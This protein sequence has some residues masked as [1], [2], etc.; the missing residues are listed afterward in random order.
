MD[1]SPPGS[2]SWDSPDRNTGVGYH[3][4]LQGI[5]PTQGSNQHLFCLLHWEVSSLPLAPSG[6]S[7]PHH[8]SLL[9]SFVSLYLAIIPGTTQE[10]SGKHWLDEFSGYIL[11]F[12]NPSPI[13]KI[14]LV[15]INYC[16]HWEVQ[17][18]KYY[19]L[20]K[21]SSTNDLSVSILA[22]AQSPP[23][24]AEDSARV[25]VHLRRK[26][27]TRVLVVWRQALGK[28]LLIEM[29]AEAGWRLSG[30]PQGHQI[31]NVENST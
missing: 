5:S 11:N 15:S 12:L 22:W 21:M 18:F 8:K 4:F 31:L 30:S 2:L 17:E 16:T 3:A 9:F 28:S 10:T 13:Q 23:S 26:G 6:K 24:L 27:G 1:H 20:T 29:N 19:S 7:M 14:I 25:L